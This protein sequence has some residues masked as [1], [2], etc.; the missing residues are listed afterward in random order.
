MRWKLKAP[1]DEATITVADCTL[2]VPLVPLHD[3][4][5][6]LVAVSAPVL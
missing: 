3:S 2:D 1:E 6:V 5:N 4:E